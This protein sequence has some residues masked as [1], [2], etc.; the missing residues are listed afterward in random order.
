MSQGLFRSPVSYTQRVLLAALV[1]A[2]IL[3]AW[4]G[5]GP[6][7]QRQVSILVDG[8]AVVVK[9]RAETVR[10]ALTVAGVTIGPRDVVIPEPGTRITGDTVV[11]VRRAVPVIFC[12]DGL[13][14]RVLSAASTVGEVLEASRVPVRPSDRLDPPRGSVVT[15]GLRVT[16]TRVVNS[17]QHRE[18]PIPRKVVRLD[19]MSMDLGQTRTVQEGQDGLLHRLLIVT[20][21]NAVEVSSRVV[22]ETVLAEPVDKIV[23][24]GT[25]G[26]IVRDG[27][28]IRFL[29]AMSVTAT[30]Y[31]PGP[32]SCGTSADGYTAL[33]LKATRGIIAVDPR[34]IPLWTKVYV[35]GYGFAVAGD[36]GSAI[37]GARVDVC[38]DTY[39]EAVRWGVRRVKVYI[40]ELPS[41]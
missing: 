37:K 20:Y 7:F 29:K 13:E 33:G 16:V 2:A 5:G 28:T 18:D 41:S 8:E 39:D 26:T 31:D 36:T 17:Y 34:V 23:R 38:F 12:L 15:P 22:S 4:F 27:Q 9:T 35:D 25:A 10:A 40:L 19:D 1:V 30:A 21:E 11:E 14:M 32:I 24:H 3:S 6:W